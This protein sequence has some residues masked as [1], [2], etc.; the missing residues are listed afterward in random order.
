VNRLGRAFVAVV[1]PD[2]VLDA[3]E[4]R[5]APLRVSHDELRWSGRAQWH[6]TLRFLGPVPDVD[7]LLRAMHEEL[8]SIPRIGGVAVAGAGA[9]PSASRASVLWL[10]IRDGAVALTRVAESVEWASVAAG[11]AP[12]A[13]AFAPHLTVARVPR[14]RDVAAVLAA[15]G[16]D[17]IGAPWP[18]DDVVLVSSDTRPT[19]AVHSEIA[20]VPLARMVE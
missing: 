14:R 19:G 8:A 9:F 7:M 18:V 13:R 1:P 4:A 17:P 5:V 10:G 3:I 16:D 12:D 11:F 20:R 6:L 15:L 2:D